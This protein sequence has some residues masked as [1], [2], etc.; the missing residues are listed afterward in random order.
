MAAGH[1]ETATRSASI[2][3]AMRTAT[4]GITNSRSPIPQVLEL[5]AKGALD[6]APVTTVLAPWADADR[7]FLEPT[8][9]VVVSHAG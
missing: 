2:P 4:T 5:V 6:P 7:A 3:L 8:T 1:S 9:K